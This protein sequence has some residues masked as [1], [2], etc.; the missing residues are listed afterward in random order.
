MN[1][2]IVNAGLNYQWQA[3]VGTAGFMIVLNN[4]G[5]VRS[6][7]HKLHHLVLGHPEGEPPLLFGQVHGTLP[8]V[9]VNAGLVPV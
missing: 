1:P 8:L 4:R 3:G 2:R 5:E 9:V 6:F 7:T